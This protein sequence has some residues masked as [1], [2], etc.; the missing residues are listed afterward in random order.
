MWP[1]LVNRFGNFFFLFGTLTYF[2]RVKHQNRLI[3]KEV[4]LF[5]TGDVVARLQ[6]MIMFKVVF[7]FKTEFGQFGR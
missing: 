1:F 5:H 6:L 2:D 3:K 7:D 4:V